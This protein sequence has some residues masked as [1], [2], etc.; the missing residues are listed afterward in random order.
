VILMLRW[1]TAILLILILANIGASALLVD[2]KGTG[3]F[4]KIQ[5]AIDASEAGGEIIVLNGTYR[6]NL[7]VDRPITLRGDGKPVIAGGNSSAPLITI[8]ASGVVLD[9]FVFS[10][11]VDERYDSGAV[12]VLSD[13]STIVNNTVSGSS[14]HGIHMLNS[15]NHLISGNLIHDNSK[16]GIQFSGANYSR[17]AA[18]DIRQNGYGIFIDRSEQNRISDSDVWD[19]RG[20]GI[21]I[22][23]TSMSEFINN[24]IHNNSE[25]GIY[26]VDSDN[27]IITGNRIR[28]CKNCGINIDRSSYVMILANTIERCGEMGVSLD[29]SNI[30][31]VTL[32][33]VSDNHLNGIAI[34]G[35]NYNTISRNLVRDNRDS[36][37]SLR[38]GSERN[39]ITNNEISAS[40]RYGLVFDGS[41][42]N[43]AQENKIYN[44]TNG[45]VML[46]SNGNSI[47][48]N[49]IK[50]NGYGLS[51][52]IVDNVIISKNE[53]VNS[54][55]DGIRLFQCYNS[56][57]WANKIRDSR[58]DG[59][60]ITSSKGT[61]VSENDIEESGGYG[62]QFL[63]HSNDNLLVSNLIKNSGLG[64]VYIFEGETNFV[65][66]CALVDNSEFSGRDNCG[67][68]CRNLWYSNY[69]SDFECEEASW[70]EEVVCANPYVIQGHRG[71]TNFDTRPFSDRSIALGR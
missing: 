49:R 14:G 69:Y 67:M 60:H 7:V 46:H 2:S 23:A 5:D 51:L 43:T 16:A 57:I 19:N 28:D 15:K 45:I 12:L 17:I 39:I 1:P 3:D 37:I 56:K 63:D 20:D 44:N 4:S 50:E 31:F 64:G 41:N 54:S 9:G 35:S 30:A 58:A 62:V 36:G 21:V 66:N 55:R 68:N 10:G 26:H 29:T 13:E 52:E 22:S 34:L 47:V 18:N 71:A 42:S 32:N 65:V 25:N 61:I 11:C 40:R 59:V 8:N 24:S 48:D 27:N 33:T 53:I 6:E 38:L 70:V